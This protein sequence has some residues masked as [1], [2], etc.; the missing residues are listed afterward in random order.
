[1]ETMTN[2]ASAASALQPERARPEEQAAI[3]TDVE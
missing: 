2:G 3:D 1:M